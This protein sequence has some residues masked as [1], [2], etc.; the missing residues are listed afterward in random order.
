MLDLLLADGA[1]ERRADKVIDARVLERAAHEAARHDV[2]AVGHVL[3]EV[4]LG[5][6]AHELF[7]LLLG[8][9]PYDHV[10]DVHHERIGR[11]AVLAHVNHLYLHIISYHIISE[12][13]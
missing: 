3:D 6:D 12:K 4:G 7:G 10:V 5:L 11:E 2:L 8:K 1:V 13:K 9:L